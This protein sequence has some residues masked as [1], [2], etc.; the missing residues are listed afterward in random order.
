MRSPRLSACQSQM[1]H[2]DV[3][4]WVKLGQYFA[5]VSCLLYLSKVQPSHVNRLALKERAIFELEALQLELDTFT[6]LTANTRLSAVFEKVSTLNRVLD[7]VGHSSD[8]DL[9]APSTLLN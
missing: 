1:E 3:K 6:P 9:P 4:T 5:S 7:I 8:Q 2:Q